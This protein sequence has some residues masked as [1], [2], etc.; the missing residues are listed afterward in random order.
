MCMIFSNY[1][2]IGYPI[3]VLFMRKFGDTYYRY[4][5]HIAHI[6]GSKILV[7]YHQLI[8]YPIYFLQISDRYYTLIRQCRYVSYM[9]PIC[10]LYVSEVYPAVILIQSKLLLMLIITGKFIT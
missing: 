5:A 9:Y 2:H 10:I 1:T 3:C 4:C 7:T 8:G 6:S